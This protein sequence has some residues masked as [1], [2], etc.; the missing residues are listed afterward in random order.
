M[1]HYL[2]I[3]TLVAICWAAGS[4]CHSRRLWSDRKPIRNGR[5]MLF[6]SSMRSHSSMHTAVVSQ[7]QTL[8]Q[9]YAYLSEDDKLLLIQFMWS[10]QNHHHVK[11]SSHEKWICGQHLTFFLQCKQKEN[12][13]R[14]WFMWSA[15]STSYL[16]WFCTLFKTWKWQSQFTVWKSTL[17]TDGLEWHEGERKM[18]GCSFVFFFLC[19]CYNC[20]KSLRVPFECVHCTAFGIQLLKQSSKKPGN[21]KIQHK[22]KR[23]PSEGYS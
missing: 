10:N 12:I 5:Q 18:T 22:V 8:E 23:C 20:Q 4:S 13:Y 19:V 9:T 6:I 2:C 3:C 15:Y 14:M 16:W 1:W 7:E 11:N 17:F 21:V